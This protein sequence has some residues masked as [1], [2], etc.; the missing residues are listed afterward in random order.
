MTRIL[1]V[2]DSPAD[3]ELMKKVLQT[4]QHEVMTLN[5]PTRAEDVILRE[6]PNILL[7]D[8]VMP[9][10]NGYE[11]L[12]TLR[13]GPQAT[14]LKVILVSSKGQDTD[15]KWGLR[16]GADDYLIKPYTPEQVLAL[17]ARHSG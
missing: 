11:I 15:V 14:P 12:R 2:D 8:V 17:V 1:I 13:R 5:D 3:L 4:A 6:R 16:Q 10:R 9:G 7:L